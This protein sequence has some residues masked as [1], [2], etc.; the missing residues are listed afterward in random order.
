MVILGG[1]TLTTDH[2][3]M[4]KMLKQECMCGRISMI[5][6]HLHKRIKDQKD[7]FKLTI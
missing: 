6:T 2:N 1:A 5:R 7:N 3:G 4:A